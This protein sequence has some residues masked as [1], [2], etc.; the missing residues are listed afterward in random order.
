[1]KKVDIWITDNKDFLYEGDSFES[2]MM[3]KINYTYKNECKELKMLRDKIEEHKN[4]MHPEQIIGDIFYKNVTIDFD[5]AKKLKLYDT[6]TSECFKS[7]TEIGKALI[8]ILSTT[9]Y[10]FTYI[11]YQRNWKSTNEIYLEF[12]LTHI[13]YVKDI[14]C[15]I[16]Q[17]K[18]NLVIE[19][20]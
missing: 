4:E 10:G 9:Y 7:E 6:I 17:G 5:F 15:L 3:L 13:E 1:M 14:H 16:N 20:D 11:L 12:L 8:Y 18:L 2:A 19:R